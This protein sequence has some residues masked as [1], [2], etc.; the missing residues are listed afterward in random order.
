MTLSENETKTT[1]PKMG[2]WPTD[3][4]DN[5][6]FTACVLFADR[7]RTLYVTPTAMFL[8]WYGVSENY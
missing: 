4:N 7:S 3:D 2:Y 8:T 1:V 5:L 6:I